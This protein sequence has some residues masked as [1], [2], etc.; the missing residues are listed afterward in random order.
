MFLFA[1]VALINGGLIGAS[2]SINGR[3]GQSAG[4]LW[5]SFWNH[6]VGFAFLTALL[7]VTGQ[8]TLGATLNA[9]AFTF[10]G[11]ILGAL[12]VTMNS[13]VLPR[14]GALTTL[15][16]VICGQMIS[17]IL[18]DFVIRHTSPTL[19]QVLGIGLVMAGTYLARSPNRRSSSSL[20]RWLAAPFVSRPTP[21]LPEQ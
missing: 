2:R 1:V 3:L 7:A 15:I 19:A 20:G 14:I 8:W 17:G 21:A 12:F 6:L 11:G 10:L 18:L 9:P 5:A 13:Y 16:L 4:S